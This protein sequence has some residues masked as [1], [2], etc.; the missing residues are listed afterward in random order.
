MNRTELDSLDKASLVEVVLRLTE[1]IA[2]LEGRLAQLEQ[3]LAEAGR[4]AVRGAAPFARPERKRSPSPKRPGR[5]GG[6][7]GMFR[8][9]PAEEE[10]DRR[11]E[12]P[13][14]DCPRCGGRLAAETDRV[15]EQTIIEVAPARAEVIR[16]VTHRNV[17]CGCGRRVASSHPL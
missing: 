16:L 8:V 4:R 12:V 5:K 17:C 1:R 10:V 7:E 14:D 9:R 6:H 11:I 13:L 3:R 15:V 2:E